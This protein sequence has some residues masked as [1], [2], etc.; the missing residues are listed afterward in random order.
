MD[1][2][3]AMSAKEDKLVKGIPFLFTNIK[4]KESIGWFNLAA[5]SKVFIS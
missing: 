4:I 1:E 5:L 3:V 2:G